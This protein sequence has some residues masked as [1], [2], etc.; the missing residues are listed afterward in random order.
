VV[1]LIPGFGTGELAGPISRQVVAEI[2]GEPLTALDVQRN[3][4]MQI[5]GRTIPPELASVFVPQLVDQMI[6]EY[7]L[8]YQAERMGFQ[9][10]EA[11][12]ALTIQSIFPELFEGGRFI[13]R[14]FYSAYLAQ[15]NLT[16]PQ[17]ERNLRKQLLLNKLR[18][19]A[20]EGIVITPEEVESEYR[21]RNEQIRIEYIAFTPER[22]R[23]EVNVTQDEI[24]DHFEKNLE[25]FR[26]PE[27]RSVEV[28]AILE[29]EIEKTVTVSEEAL[30]RAYQEEQEIY[31]I[32]ERVNVRHILLT[33]TEKPQDEMPAIRAKAEDLLNRIK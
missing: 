8:A 4:Q 10:T 18:S 15:Q 17:F 24:R 12:L 22:F 21:R 7:A 3:I 26:L 5:R 19:L 16:I 23:A 11:D 1:T 30:R 31:R 20:L 9:V 2:G 32:P 33:T 28:V 14:E 29:S 6:T 25:R 27:R 13:G